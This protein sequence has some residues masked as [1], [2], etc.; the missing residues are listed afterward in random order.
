MAQK[1]QT[2]VHIVSE[3]LLRILCLLFLWNGMCWFYRTA[4]K[5]RSSAGSASQDTQHWDLA[6]V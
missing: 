4:S 3:T 5:C 6:V 1:Q 2:I